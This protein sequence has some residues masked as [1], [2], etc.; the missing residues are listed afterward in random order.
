MDAYNNNYIYLVRNDGATT[1]MTTSSRQQWY[2]EDSQMMNVCGAYSPSTNSYI[3]C[4]GNDNN[5]YY[6]K[7]Y[8]DTSWI[9]VNVS[10][11][12]DISTYSY[13]IDPYSTS[14]AYIVRSDGMINRL[15]TS[16]LQVS[17]SNWTYGYATDMLKCSSTYSS[18]SAIRVGCI[19]KDG[20]YYYR[21]DYDT[22]TAYIKTPSISK[23]ESLLDSNSW[24]DMYSTTH[25]DIIQTDGTN[26]YNS[27]FNYNSSPSW[28]TSNIP[29]GGVKT[30]TSGGNLTNNYCIGNDNK[31]YYKSY[32]STSWTSTSVTVN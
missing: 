32:S 16:G 31:L 15:G 21:D 17:S 10:S 8:T 14:Y 5:A 1:L 27:H 9:K 22:T 2:T 20:F 18:S 11:Y 12:I 30:C 24:I 7:T 13:S 4:I 28:Y 25:T 6:K 26:M 19:G 29:G 23:L 3:W